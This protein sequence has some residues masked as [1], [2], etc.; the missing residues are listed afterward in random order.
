MQPDLY[1]VLG[2]DRGASP[3]ALKKAFRKQALRFHPDRNP[4]DAQAERRFKEVTY[5]YSILSDPAKKVQY[6]RFGR[7]FSE[8]RSQGPWGV[9]DEVD[10][11]EMVGQVFKDLFRGRRQKAAKRRRD[12]RYTVTITLAEAAVGT[13]KT[14]E[15]ERPE[16]DSRVREKLAVK[17]PAGVDTGQ[18]LKV[19]GKG[20]TGTRGTGDLY[21]VVNVSEHSFFKRRAADVFCDLPLSYSQAMLGGEV[22]VPT[23]HGPAVIRLPAGTQPG[24][25]LTLKGKGLR[26]LSGPQA[27]RPGDQYVCVVLDMPSSVSDAA[28]D[29][30]QRLD[31][32]LGV[33]R[34]P[35]R[36]AFEQAL[37][38]AEESG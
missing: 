13:T 32:E 20:G 14:I 16:G 27:G 22:T 19:S 9:S 26:R 23:L 30:L 12:L 38:P 34:T 11:G 33:A 1:Q 4:D 6:D 21:V 37:R 28:A 36:E 29:L 5:A 35:L 8:G 24:S 2:V 17:V 15:F 25:V 7:V 10:L 3:E 18:K 31:G